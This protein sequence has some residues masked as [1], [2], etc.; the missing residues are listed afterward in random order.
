MI[1]KTIIVPG[2]DCGYRGVDCQ[3]DPRGD[4]GRSGDEVVFHVVEDDG[5][6]STSM[7]VRTCCLNGEPHGVCKPKGEWGGN[8]GTADHDKP[9]GDSIYYH[10]PWRTSDEDIRSGATGSECGLI[11]SGR[12]FGDG[13][14][15]DAVAIWRRHGRVLA[16]I[17]DAAVGQTPQQLIDAQ[18]DDLW[19]AIEDW[20][21]AKMDYLESH[22]PRT[23]QC[24][25]C[26]GDGIV[27]ED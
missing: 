26:R 3:H 25:T 12:C 13:C 10:V 18:G 23:R 9:C 16:P 15:L 17:P 8:F 22:R 11:R 19:A 6:T 5:S 14:V 24:P 2:F 4:H 20:H 7:K 21:R 27:P 1:R